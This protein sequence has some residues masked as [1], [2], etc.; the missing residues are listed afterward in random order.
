MSRD[1]IN[2]PAFP[3]APYEGD[4]VNPPVR[5]NSGMSFRDYIATAAMQSL[6]SDKTANDPEAV[7][8]NAYAFADAM[9]EE[10]QYSARK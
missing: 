1:P 6:V 4:S 8:E 10:R 9:L 3:V 7:A 2:H 5:S